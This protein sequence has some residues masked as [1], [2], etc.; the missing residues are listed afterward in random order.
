MLELP[1]NIENELLRLRAYFPYRII[2]CAHR[3]GE[4]VTGANT[5][6]GQANKYAR[7]GYQVFFVK[8]VKE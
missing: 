6:K 2:W 3:N 7:D 5:D 4:W 1:Q 8:G